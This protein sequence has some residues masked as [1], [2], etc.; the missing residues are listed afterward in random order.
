MIDRLECDLCH[1]N[2]WY[3]CQLKLITDTHCRILTC[4]IAALGQAVSMYSQ[5]ER[6]AYHVS[7]YREEIQQLTMTVPK[8]TYTCYQT[9]C[10]ITRHLSRAHVLYGSSSTSAFANDERAFASALF[11]G[12]VPQ[13]NAAQ[14]ENKPG[15]AANVH[16]LFLSLSLSLE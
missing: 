4:P 3:V 6:Q 16:S 7:I 13:Q 14:E 11:N 1:F 2:Y 9:R 8:D 10:S 12:A 15:I 5:L